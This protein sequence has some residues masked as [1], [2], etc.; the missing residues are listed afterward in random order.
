MDKVSRETRSRMMS[1]IK[2]KDTAPELL[3]RSYLHKKGF[4]FRLHQKDLPGKPDIVLKKYRTCIFVNGCFWHRP[5][6]DRC[7]NCRMPKTNKSFWK[8]KL[9]ANI[10]RD[11]LSQKKLEGSGWNCISVWECDLKEERSLEDLY[12]SIKLIYK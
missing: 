9:S 10:K 2:A 3:V 7:S 5:L 12:N 8:D 4:R 11:K 1:R 6:K